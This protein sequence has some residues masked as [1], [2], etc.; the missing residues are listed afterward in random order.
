VASLPARIAARNAHVAQ[1]QKLARE[2]MFCVETA[3]KLLYFSELAYSLEE[4][5]DAVAEANGFTRAAAVPAAAASA[6]EEAAQGVAVDVD[7]EAVPASSASKDSEGDEQA[8]TES[9]AAAR[10]S[11]GSLDVALLLY[12]TPHHEL[13]WDRD[14][15]IKALLT[16]S[17]DTLVLAFKG[18]SSFENVLTD[19]DVSLALLRTTPGRAPNCVR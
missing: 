6:A 9:E 15:D 18:T 2:P 16:W 19:L 17:H 10:A 13:V 14:T 4:A 3:I 5:E 8:E 1:S 7:V 11:K 12:D